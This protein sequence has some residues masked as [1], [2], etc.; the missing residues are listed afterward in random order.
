MVSLEYPVRTFGFSLVRNEKSKLGWSHLLNQ[1]VFNRRVIVSAGFP[2][3]EEIPSDLTLDKVTG[4]DQQFYLTVIPPV[5]SAFG[6]IVIV[7]AL[8]AFVARPRYTHIIRDAARRAG[9]T[10]SGPTAWRATDG[11]L[12]FFS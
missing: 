3:G 7:E 5:R 1:P 4:K 10:V 11:V 2:S 9:P 6:L 12:V 8:I